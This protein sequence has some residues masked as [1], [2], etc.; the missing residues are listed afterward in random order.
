M[1]LYRQI[2]LFTTSCLVLHRNNKTDLYLSVDYSLCSS[3]ASFSNFFLFNE[4]DNKVE[5]DKE[6]FHD[7]AE[8]IIEF[9]QLIYDKTYRG[10]MDD[11]D[12]RIIDLLYDLLKKWSTYNQT[13]HS[14]INAAPINHRDVIFIHASDDINAVRLQILI[15]KDGFFLEMSI[16]CPENMPGMADDFWLQWLELNRFGNFELIEHEPFSNNDKKHHPRLFPVE[17][18]NI[19]NI[20]RSMIAFPLIYERQIEWNS[21]SINWPFDQ[22]ST[23]EVFEKGCLAFE[24][25]CHLN[26]RLLAGK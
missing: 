13:Y 24:R 26:R 21:L 20:M 7:H 4:I 12:I 16:A 1:L 3:V 9:N 2:I 17:A 19:F 15:N 5:P 6:Q 25:L 23:K 11:L 10:D 18:S 22:Y 14:W 8:T